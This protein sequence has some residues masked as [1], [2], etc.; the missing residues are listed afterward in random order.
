MLGPQGA[1]SSRSGPNPR[2]SHKQNKITTPKLEQS[3]LSKIQFLD[4]QK[5]QNNLCSLSFK[6]QEQNNSAHKASATS[7]ASEQLRSGNS[8]R[9]KLSKLSRISI[10]AHSRKDAENS[11][12][13]RKAA[14][15]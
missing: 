9:T 12:S 7:F 1:I 6:R 5:D 2:S 15:N 14:L 3:K 10:N 11:T 4:L 8:K 13:G